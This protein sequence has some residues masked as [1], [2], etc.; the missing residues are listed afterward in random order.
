MPG[1]P[2]GYGGAFQAY[3]ASTS[4]RDTIVFKAVKRADP[5]ITIYNPASGVI[6]NAGN[7]SNSDAN[8]VWATGDVGESCFNVSATCSSGK[9]MGWHWVADSR[10]T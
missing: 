1:T 7:R 4:A 2:G 10:I 6:G 8:T 5:A 3:T 9:H